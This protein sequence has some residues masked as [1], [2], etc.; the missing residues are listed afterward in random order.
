MQEGRIESVE[1]IRTKNKAIQRVVELVA[2][3][4]RGR[5]PVR[6]AVTHANS[7]ADALSLLESARAVLDPVETM[8]VPLSPVIGTHAGPGTVAL[9]FTC[10]IA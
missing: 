1:R 7:E 3:R 9:N 6:L 2:E 4:V 8:C 5:T 10:G